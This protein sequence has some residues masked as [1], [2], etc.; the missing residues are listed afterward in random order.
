MRMAN[1]IAYFVTV[2]ATKKKSFIAM[3]NT[4]AYFV[5]ASEAKKKSFKAMQML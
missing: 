1:T 5:M 2:S 4:L 3:A